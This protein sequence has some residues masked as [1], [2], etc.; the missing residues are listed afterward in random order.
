MSN[1]PTESLPDQLPGPGHTMEQRDETGVVFRIITTDDQ[2]RTTMTAPPGPPGETREDAIARI[3]R[4]APPLSEAQ[5]ARLAVL[6]APTSGRGNTAARL[7]Q[8][9]A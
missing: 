6:L 7:T 2:G 5:V 8:P 4:A 9:P 3:V 1:R